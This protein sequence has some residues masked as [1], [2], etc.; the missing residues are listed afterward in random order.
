VFVVVE[1]LIKF[2][3]MAF[4]EEGKIEEGRLGM[5]NKKKERKK[6]QRTDTR[7]F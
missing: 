7:T 4:G 1:V 3:M 5:G 6:K 2:K